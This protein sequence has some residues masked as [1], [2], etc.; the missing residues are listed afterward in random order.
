MKFKK[1]S[2]GVFIPEYFK[3]EFINHSKVIYTICPNDSSDETTSGVLKKRDQLPESLHDAYLDFAN[4]QR[5]SDKFVNKICEDY[6]NQD[7]RE[8]IPANLNISLIVDEKA[9]DNL[10]MNL[11]YEICLESNIHRARKGLLLYGEIT[12]K[13][14]QK[15]EELDES[16]KFNYVSRGIDREKFYSER[17]TCKRSMKQLKEDFEN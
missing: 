15:L 3:S 9:S 4:Q 10:I 7:T 17:E 16:P 14:Y 2:L 13:E 11:N 5:E 8:F 6:Y 12:P 1:K